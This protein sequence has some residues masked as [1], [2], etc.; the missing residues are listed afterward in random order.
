M[1]SFK[2][3]LKIL[4]LSTYSHRCIHVS[5][6]SRLLAGSSKVHHCIDSNPFT[7]LLLL[8]GVPVMLGGTD[9]LLEGRR[10]LLLSKVA[11]PGDKYCALSD[12][13]R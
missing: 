1:N 12:F 4:A 10:S 11:E 2:P 6:L 5:K 7:Q 9:I 8:W 13:V 3:I